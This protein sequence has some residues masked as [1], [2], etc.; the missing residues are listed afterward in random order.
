MLVLPT[1]AEPHLAF[2]QWPSLPSTLFSGSGH[3]DPRVQII[4]L[5]W[6]SGPPHSFLQLPFTEWQALCFTAL[7]SFLLAE[8]IYWKVN[9]CSRFYDNKC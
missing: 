7:W 9:M 1:P 2:A 4:A 6:A 3:S 5:T 8:R